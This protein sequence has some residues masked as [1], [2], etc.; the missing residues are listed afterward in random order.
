MTDIVTITSDKCDDLRFVTMMAKEGL[1][2]LFDFYVQFE[3]QDIAIDLSGLLGSSMTVTIAT[4]DGF[5]R[6][7]NG[8]VIRANQTG[9]ETI[10]N[11]V[12]A[13]YEVSL[14]PK[15]W[16][17]RQKVDCRI[18]KQ[19]SAPD[20]IKQVLSE[21][22]YSDIKLS[23]SGS[24]A[25]RDYCVQYREDYF[26]FISRLME[27]EGIYYYFTHTAGTHT[28]VLAD[29]IGGHQKVDGFSKVAYASSSDS[30]LRREATIVSWGTLRSVDKTKYALT[31]FDPQ[32]PKASLL[33]LGNTDGHGAA[34]ADDVLDVFDFPG[35]HVTAAV[36]AHY[37]QVR[38]EALTAW[39]SRYSG[40]TGTP[41]VQI[42][43][44]FTLSN[45]PRD[46]LN[47]EYLIVGSDIQLHAPPHGPGGGGG[48]VSFHCS[49]NAIESKTPFRSM[50]MAK[51]PTIVGLQTA[52]VT[53]SETSEDIAV[54]KYGRVE[55]TFHW[56]TPDKKNAKCSCPVRV[57]TPWAGK[58]W[59]AISIPRV[60]QEVVVSFLEGDPDRP[61]IIG[62]VYNGDNQ[63]PYSLP[64]NKTQSGI[65]SRS[66]LGGTADFNELRFEDKKGS[67]D[68]FM[69]AQKDMHE[70]V[71][72][73]HIVTI[74]HDE[75]VTIKHDRKATISNNDTIDVGQ[76]FKLTAGTQIELTTGS[77]SI[78]MKSTGEIQITGVN[79]TITGNSSVKV[80][81]QVQV[82][83]KAGATMDVGAGAS[84]KVHSDG[85]L[86][87]EGSAMTTVKGTMVS[88]T[89]DAMTKVSGGIIMIG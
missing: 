52:I 54:D 46:E 11:L 19:L 43:G 81:G 22:G 75:T 16:L 6:Y 9:V 47:Q 59:G 10:E 44:L 73:D 89:G 58:N 48:S 4:E 8:M 56:N 21:I 65:K 20:I 27:Q 37:A 60:G 29:G 61:L 18:Y 86:E 31:D 24:Y 71:E 41:S 1:G 30:V 67:E 32:A 7:F 80:E 88:A 85:M 79:I 82:G 17:L 66:L 87:V 34:E 38:A 28:L 74:D 33:S 62:S 35:G 40:A 14:A 26:N 72:N 50:Q 15:P 25:T 78:I 76:I 5:K 12:Y 55:V 77:S 23:L 39:H 57:A 51:K 3:S 53:G 68:F 69:H 13:T 63:V 45:F 42:G 83:I 84:M 36:G 64:D 70:E 49:F 2:Q